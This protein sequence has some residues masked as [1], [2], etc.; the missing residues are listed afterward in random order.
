MAQLFAS[1]NLKFFAKVQYSH[2]RKL[3]SFLRKNIQSEADAARVSRAL[4]VM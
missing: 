4:F 3:I 1:S 2:L